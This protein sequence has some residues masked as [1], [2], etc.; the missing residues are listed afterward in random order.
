MHVAFW[1]VFLQ[2][3]GTKMTAFIQFQQCLELH[4]LKNNNARS[5]AWTGDLRQ[6]TCM[7]A[8]E[9]EGAFFWPITFCHLC[10]DTQGKITLYTVQR[11]S[12]QGSVSC[13]S[14]FITRG[15]ILS[16]K[17]QFL[18]CLVLCKEIPQ[19]PI[20]ESLRILQSSKIRSHKAEFSTTNLSQKG[21]VTAHF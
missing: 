4:V 13:I 21:W 18:H 3:E 11:G 16:A 12:D 7:M 15:P 5:S 19:L 17:W 20:L 14:L 2:F 10:C 6:S 9:W 1:S 8:N